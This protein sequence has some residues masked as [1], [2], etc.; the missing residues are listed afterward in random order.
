MKLRLLA[1]ALI[2]LL[3]VSAGLARRAAR[4]LEPVAELAQPVLFD[5]EPGASLARV[6]AALER[7]G[8]VR[9]ALATKLVARF[10]GLESRLQSGEYELSPDLS[11]REIL[12]LIAS[13]RVKTW[14][15][16]LPEGS[17]ATEIAARLERSGLADAA[18]F[19]AAGNDPAFA[20]ELGLQGETPD[21]HLYPS[22]YHLPRGRAGRHLART[23]AAPF[24]RLSVSGTTSTSSNAPIG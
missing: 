3:L 13:G 19:M 7:E 21:G 16:T 20:H 5:V 18:A 9:S 1:I 4:M 2:T 6:A 12:A 17:R 24:Q 11:T 14:P 22:T 8:L 23:I 10:D 15:V